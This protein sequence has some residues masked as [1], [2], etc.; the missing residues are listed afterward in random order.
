LS[1]DRAT[2]SGLAYPSDFAPYKP[3]CDVAVVT[4]AALD[5]QQPG[6]LAVGTLQKN[7]DAMASL[8]ARETFCPDGDPTEASALEAWSTGQIDFVRFQA[9]PP[10]Q[11]MRWP[12]AGFGVDYA[13]GPHVLSG[14]FE[15]PFVRASVTT[16]DGARVLARVPMLLDTVLLEPTQRRMFAVFRGIFD[17]TYADNVPERIAFDLT[18]NGVYDPRFFASWPVG[19]L[20]TPSTSHGTATQSAPGDAALGAPAETRVLSGP[21]SSVALPFGPKSAPASRA[22]AETPPLEATVAAPFDDTTAPAVRPSA[23]TLPFPK[24]ASSLG[25]PHARISSD[26]LQAL[27][28]Q[29]E[30]PVAEAWQAGNETVLGIPAVD[31]AKLV[32]APAPLA[33]LA[34]FGAP[35]SV[36]PPASAP[37]PTSASPGVASGGWPV[38]GAAPLGA[39][40]QPSA[41]PPPAPAPPPPVAPS[42]VGPAASQPRALDARPPSPALSDAERVQ[43]I[44]KEIWAGERSQADILASHGLSE[45]DWRA[46]RR[47]AAKPG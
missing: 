41:A 44:L 14:R 43:A 15:G 19:K 33:P 38:L 30:K 47:S 10:D 42:T 27:R 13:R 21:V 11:R 22:P 35:R 5:R 25:A 18:P 45:L 39:V 4:A 40:A 34:A 12:T 6:R 46:L 7:V 31:P 24:S 8:G 37:P 17:R 2:G 16:T 3:S 9:T 1:L 23:M 28:E 36:S 29:G 20:A 26:D 32:G